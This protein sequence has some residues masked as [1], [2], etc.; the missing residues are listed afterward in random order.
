MNSSLIAIQKLTTTLITRFPQSE[1]FLVGGAVRDLIMGREVGDMDVIVRGV[2][3]QRLITF[4]KTQGK[5]NLVGKNF[6]V[7][8]FTPHRNEVSDAGFTPKGSD[9]SLDIALPRTDHAFNTGGYRDVKVAYDHT[10]PIEKDLERRDFTCNAMALKLESRIKSQESRPLLSPPLVKG[11]T[12][13]GVNPNLIDPF[14]GLKDIEN[15]I[16]R[17]VGNPETRFKEDYTRM[18]RV[19]RFSC[20]LGFEIEKKTWGSIKKN[21]KK[22]NTKSQNHKITK[23]PS[24]VSPLRRGRVGGGGL[25]ATSYKLQDFVV[26]RELVAKEFLKGMYHNPIKMLELMDKS[27]LLKELIPELLPMK[28]CKQD[29]KWH[30]EGT[31]WVHT[32]LAL[33]LASKFKV[34]SSKFKVTKLPNYPITQLHSI[35][36]TLELYLGILFHDLGKPQTAGHEKNDDKKAITYYGHETVGAEM[37]RA[38]CERLKLS[39][40]EEFG[41]NVDHVVWLVKNHMLLH[42]EI[43]DNMR[44][45]TIE[46]YFFNS[47]VPGKT[48]LGVC[49]F[50]GLASV[51]KGRSLPLKVRGNKGVMN[52]NSHNSPNLP[53]LMGGT[54]TN[55]LKSW[56]SLQGWWKATARIKK[57]SKGRMELPKPLLNGNEIMKLLNIKPGPEVGKVI[58]QLREA[59]LSRKVTN[60]TEAK[61]FIKTL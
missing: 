47:L 40:P 16:I 35:Q 57:L 52:Q 11:R 18:L 31:V 33:K 41:I 32:M 42:P 59:Q 22:I 10:L 49:F 17:A 3:I 24:F 7:I 12:G 27:G 51:P 48:L 1:V 15:K 19:L 4:L 60:T 23:T 55:A 29:A 53:Y 46:K 58:E 44:N 56:P 13:G 5:A 20:Q 34:Q 6:G 9:K 30:S 28:T 43:V 14:G 45:N 2:P 39:A 38:I 36:E 37:T 54:N 21:V 26:A 50:D 8:K 61:T 25:Q